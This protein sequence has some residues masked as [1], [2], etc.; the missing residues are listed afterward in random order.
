MVILEPEG[1]VV[2][3]DRW[4]V[5]EVQRE[6]PWE[7]EGAL[8]EQGQRWLLGIKG[9]VGAHSKLWVLSFLHFLSQ[10]M[11]VG[12]RMWAIQPC[13]LAQHR[14]PPPKTQEFHIG[15]TSGV[16]AHCRSDGSTP[17]DRKPGLQQAQP[18]EPWVCRQAQKTVTS[19][20][21]K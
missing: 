20:E 8:R 4:C 6:E 3:S 13:C 2:N 19:L 1:K 18:S 10:R 5:R 15:G 11:R 12:V 9:S 7:G 16:S 21:Q 14:G 17:S